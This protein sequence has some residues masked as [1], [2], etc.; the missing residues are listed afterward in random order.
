MPDFAPCAGVD[1]EQRIG[2]CHVENAIHLERRTA[3]IGRGVGRL[4]SGPIRVSGRRL[5]VDSGDPGESEAFDRAGIDLPERAVTF[6]GVIAAEGW[7]HIRFRMNE[8]GLTDGLGARNGRG[9]VRH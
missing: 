9:G 5:H 8:I 6:A 4:I 2:L 1:G 3:V 7:P